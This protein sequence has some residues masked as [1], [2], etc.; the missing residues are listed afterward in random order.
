MVADPC[1]QKVQEIKLVR[2]EDE[3]PRAWDRVLQEL[4]ETDGV[5]VERLEG[6]SVKIGWRKYVDL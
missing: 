5:T 3:L 6:D 4:D 2:R 1:A